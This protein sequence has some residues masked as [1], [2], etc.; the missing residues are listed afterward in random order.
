M[1]RYSFTLMAIIVFSVSL[2]GQRSYITGDSEMIFSVAD[3]T[4]GGVGMDSHLRW[5]TF[6]HSA[7]YHNY[8]VCSNFGFYYG[9]ALRNVGFI[10]RDESIGGTLYNMVKR[11]SYSL[12]LPVGIKLGDINRNTFIFGG[13]E[14]EWMF[15]I[16]RNVLLMV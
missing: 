1:K 14:Y 7:T 11:R 10:T 5:T 9:L 3:I 2:Y 15:I 4:K 16:R 6:Y 12:G 13:V 8:D